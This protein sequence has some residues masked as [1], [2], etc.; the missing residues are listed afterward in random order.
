MPKIRKSHGR[1]QSETKAYEIAQAREYM[2][3]KHNDLVRN[4]KFLLSKNSEGTSLS[5]LEQKVILYIISRIKPTD[6]E[7][8]ELIF[9]I[10][11][12]YKICGFLDGNTNYQYLKHVIAKLKGRVMWLVSEDSETTVSWIDKATLYKN[13]GKIKIRFD[14]DMKPYLLMLS[15]NRTQFPLHNVIRMKSKYGIMLYQ[16]LKSYAF[17]APAIEYTIQELKESLDCHQYESISNLKTNVIN[18]ALKDINEYTE[19]EV[20]AEYLKTGRAI[21]SVIFHIKDLSKSKELRDQDEAN[22]RFYNTEKEIYQFSLYDLIQR[23][24]EAQDDGNE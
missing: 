11:D 3:A 6:T 1:G 9:D 7:L 5:L 21:T 13:S 8:P 16:I 17:Q 2:V 12:F 24:R 20:S 15:K 4:N 18:P 19:L 23:N 22:R 14:E 10:Q